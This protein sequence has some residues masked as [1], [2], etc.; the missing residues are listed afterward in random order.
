MIPLLVLPHLL[1]SDGRQSGSAFNFVPF[2]V[3]WRRMNI[4]VGYI[5]REMPAIISHVLHIA[6]GI[7]AAFGI[8]KFQSIRKH[9][10]SDQLEYL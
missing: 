4:D 6:M 9:N 7:T 2:P 8:T 3:V 5:R 10:A 1:L